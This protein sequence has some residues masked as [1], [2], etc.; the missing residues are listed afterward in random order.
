MELY[1]QTWAKRWT[2]KYISGEE[3]P[4][5]GPMGVG[6]IWAGLREP[7]G[8]VS[9]SSSFLCQAFWGER[10]QMGR[11]T[12]RGSASGFRL[13]VGWRI[14]WREE[15]CRGRGFGVFQGRPNKHLHEKRWRSIE[16]GSGI[17]PFLS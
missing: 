2:K 12:L 1:K 5:C 10:K 13:L 15:H 11:A 8:N 3:V 17:E 9:L 16:K 14:G 6:G 4:G 7:N